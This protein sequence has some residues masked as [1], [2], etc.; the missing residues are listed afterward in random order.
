ME[1]RVSDKDNVTTNP[2]STRGT[3]PPQITPPEKHQATTATITTADTE[4]E[5]VTDHMK[6]FP[7][8]ML[9][10]GICISL[11]LSTLESTIVST[12]LVAVSD[13]LSGFE[14]R[15]WV[16]TA[17]FLTYTGFLVIYAKLASIFGS[18]TLFLFALGMFTVFSIGCGLVGNITQL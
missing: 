17:Y 5:Y 1:E 8:Y 10:A 4:S 18:K 15:N 9:T 3:D 16:A 13:S 12:S 6:G 2:P 11:F 14:A 7:L